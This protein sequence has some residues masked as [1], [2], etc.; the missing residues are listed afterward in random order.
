MRGYDY[1]YCVCYSCKKIA[2]WKYCDADSNP[3]RYYCDP[4]SV[5]LLQALKDARFRASWDNS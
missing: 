2:V 3:H 5:K 1:G 4:C